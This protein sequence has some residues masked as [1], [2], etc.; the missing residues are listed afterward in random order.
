MKI[1]HLCLGCFYVDNYS[2]QENMLPKYHKKIGHE[3]SIIASL[4]SFDESGKGCYLEKGGT[5][6]NEYGIKVTRLNNYRYFKRIS[7]FMRLY[8]NTY[9]TIEKE[10]PDIIFIHGC[11]FWDIHKVVKYLKRNSRVK[12]YFDNHADFSNSATNWISK[13][14]MHRIVWRYCAKTIEPFTRKIYGVLPAR[15]DFLIDMYK[16]PSEK[17]EFLPMGADDEKVISFRSNYIK[18]SICKKYQ[19][20]HHD[21]IIITGGKIDNSKRQILTLMKSVNELDNKNIKLII[22]GTV[23]KELEDE[24]YRLLNSDRIKYIGWINSEETYEY[25]SIAD[26]AIFPGRHSVLWEQAAGS[27]IPMIV[28]YWDGTTHIDLNGNVEYLYN[29]TKEEMKSKIEYIVNN[30]V[31]YKNMRRIAESKG[32]EEFSYLKIAQRSIK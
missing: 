32:M 18:E 7:R 14:I 28:K 21:F 30:E 19:L 1:L 31:H 27:G 23:I 20:T 10:N 6:I 11:Q 12:V 25:F 15:V 5:Y 3:V 2:Y 17:V 29:D 22:F 26:L 16:M 9:K 8:K 4:L 13:N 24:F